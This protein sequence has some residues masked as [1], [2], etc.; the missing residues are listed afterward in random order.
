M[1]H[2][3]HRRLFLPLKSL[4]GGL[5]LS[6][7]ISAALG[8]EG[9]P[10][11]ELEKLEAALSASEKAEGSAAR[12]R[13][14][15]KRVVRDA[16]KL[17]EAHAAAPNRFAVL[18]ILFRAQQQLFGLDGSPRNR[19]A[20]L[21]TAEALI[22]APDEFAEQRLDADLLLT[23]TKLARRGAGAP[24]RM[25]A[26]N[27]MVSRYRDTSGEKRMLQTA[28]VM[29][30]ELGDSR[31]VRDLRKI[32][33]ER[34]SSDFEMINFQREK[35]GGQV[36]GA[37]F[38]GV[39]QR[40]DGGTMH[41]PGD[42]LGRTLLLY[43]W[44]S[45]KDGRADLEALASYW[46]AH[47][48]EIAGRVHIVSL[49]VD[50]L[51]DAGEKILRELGVEWPALHLPGGRKN[52][53]YEIFAKRDTALVTVTPTGQAAIVMLGATR[54]RKVDGDGVRDF[55]R[56]F[57]S[58]LARTW[59]EE[60]YVNQL[61]SIF[62]GDFL[63]TGDEDDFR[64]DA[65]TIPA[66][67]LKAIQDCFVAPP[68]RYRMTLEEI[69]TNYE[70]ALD[71]TGKALTAH[72]GD[73]DL[74]VVRNRRIVAHLGLWKL[75]ANHSHFLEA[76]KE[77]RISLEG[78]APPAAR[79]V[80]R[81]V[82]AK[83]QLR[84]PDCAH[85]D[86]IAGLVQSLGGDK[87]PP[88]AL[89]VASLLSLDVADRAG[90]EHYRSL[91]LGKH[92]DDPSMW[93]FGSF[94]LDRHH[95]YWLYRVPFVAGWTYGRRSGVLMSKGDPD[96]VERSFKGTLETLDGEPYNL[97]VEGADQWTIVLFTAAWTDSKKARIYSTVGRYLTPK[98][99]KRGLKDVKVVVAVMG[100]DARS[101]KAVLEERPLECD[102]LMV[103]GGVNHPLVKQFGVLDEDERS[104]ALV[105]RPDGR[106]AIFL[107]GLS[108]ARAKG[109]VLINVIEWQDHRT[110][111][112][113]LEAGQLDAAQ[114]M[115]MTLAPPFD[116]E[117]V[118]AKGRKLKKPEYPLAHLR[119]RA[120]VYLAMREWD[121]ALS[122][123]L[124]VAKRKMQKDGWMSLRTEQLDEDEAFLE[125]VRQAKAAASK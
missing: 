69:R 65:T 6:L 94:L 35:L 7:M 121:K 68:V 48:E 34:F 72:D 112:G 70:K 54:R 73:S 89:A 77:A 75:T 42:G 44:K 25:A 86:I 52:P 37:P 124:E 12:K 71:L 58:S 11:P 19:T 85:K 49:N 64:A 59:T 10:A 95:R 90:H 79:V 113:L 108:M 50:Q 78:D 4:L 16:G 97:P 30:L 83:E 99:E 82:L 107:S 29:A 46:K 98:L 1:I 39:F 26:L 100:S 27:E 96:E 57:G 41:L 9:I 23:Q 20:V 43:F 81:Y 74:W 105:I 84:Q 87:A 93:T 125:Q 119:A 55:E 53:R 14:A 91:I 51:P 56:W 17:L 110:V 101:V 21:E 88:Q 114:K 32:M 62:A 13:L 18:G 36:F 120:R 117:A 60:R 109:D 38:C 122:D 3:F 5:A 111:V 123:A 40:S 31:V 67:T 47:R 102:V 33:D 118:D 8:A 106:V 116:P 61:T 28:M 103:P 22:K 45:G 24:E 63:V 115:I 15:V 80:P 92:L 2:F 104:N 66:E 76:V